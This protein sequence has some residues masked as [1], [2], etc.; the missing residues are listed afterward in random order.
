MALIKDAHASIDR[1]GQSRY[2]KGVQEPPTKGGDRHG[3]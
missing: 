2:N 1:Q 3:P